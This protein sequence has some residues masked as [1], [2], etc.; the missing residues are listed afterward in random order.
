MLVE[1]YLPK[2]VYTY[3]VEPLRRGATFLLGE[4]QYFVLG[5]NRPYSADSRM[6]GPVDRKQIKRRVPLPED[7]VCAYFARYT[8]PEYG[9]T[10]IRPLTAH[11]ASLAS[12]L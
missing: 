12:R 4:G 9:K 1:P 5:D 11:P 6:Y 2:H 10:L 3:P 7:F 8:L